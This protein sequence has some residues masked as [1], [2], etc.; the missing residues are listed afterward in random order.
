MR[1]IDGRGEIKEDM[2]NQGAK[3]LTAGRLERE[4]LIEH[5]GLEPATAL[6]P[7]V[8]GGVHR[9][10]AD[11]QDMVLKIHH[12]L[13]R[14]NFHSLSE[15]YALCS[16]E[17]LIPRVHPTRAGALLG[18]TA[19]LVFSVQDYLAPDH[20]APAVPQVV[21]PWLARLHVVLSRL[22]SGPLA[23]HLQR[24]APDLLSTAEQYGY[25]RLR[26]FIEEAEE[27][28]RLETSQVVHGDIHPNNVISRAGRAW[29]IDL[30]SATT[31]VAASDVAFA[32]FRLCQGQPDGVSIFVE[33]YNSA[34]PPVQVADGHIL[35]FLV[36][37]ILQRL[38]FILV[39]AQ[40]GR[41]EWMVDLDN[42][43]RF[44][45]LALE[46]LSTGK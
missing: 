6:T 8:G 35:P 20:R 38:L 23:N 22:D 30:D 5:Y 40:A 11:G 12:S 25:G 19:D 3:A 31:L 7:L 18:R 29:F 34:G 39:E 45:S 24:V 1:R 46:R 36:Y 16:Q 33:G 21:A 13:S 37:N 42:Q 9:F 44:L 28:I 27:A 15:V 2:S 17:R 26:P 4:L 32:A 41:P 43:K 10:Q 14:P